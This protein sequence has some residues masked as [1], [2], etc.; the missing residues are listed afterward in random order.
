[1]HAP[2]EAGATVKDP[3]TSFTGTVVRL[4]GHT[5]SSLA[6]VPF[7]QPE[8]VVALFARLAAEAVPFAQPAAAVGLFAR[9]EAEAVPFAPRVAAMAPFARLAAAAAPFAQPVAA[10][11]PFARSEAEAVPFA[12]PVV[13]SGLGR[14]VF[15]L[16]EA[17]ACRWTPARIVPQVCR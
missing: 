4:V 7:A 3:L 12:R 2:A 13:A 8:A 9:S 1:M 16:S 10:V 14:P 6:V 15:R 11:A 17:A 5:V